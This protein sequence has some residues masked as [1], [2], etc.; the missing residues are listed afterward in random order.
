M[1]NLARRGFLA[2][3]AA[4]AAGCS[5]P[6]VK[7]DAP[8][9]STPQ[10][11][12]REMLA[13]AKV[14]PQDVL[15]DLGCGDGRIVLAAAVEHGARGVGIDIDPARIAEADAGARRAGVSDRVRFAVQ[16]LF[17]TDFSPATTAPWAST[18]QRQTSRSGFSASRDWSCSRS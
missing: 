15:Y 3:T 16:D 11:V 4:L 12:V 14:G 18:H 9:V 7:L 17:K 13:L 5:T 2:A 6:G 1:T 8:Y 10:D